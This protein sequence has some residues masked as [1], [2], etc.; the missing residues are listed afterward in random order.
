MDFSAALDL[1]KNISAAMLG[2][3][4]PKATQF[5]SFGTGTRAAA[6]SVA[7][8]MSSSVNGVGI[9][10]KN[11]DSFSIKVLTR[12]GLSVDHSYLSQYYG[13]PQ[14]DIL[15]ERVGRIE[16]KDLRSRQRPLFPG[17]SAG[18]YKI[19]AGTLGC[20]VEDE[21]KR[22][23]ILSNNHVLANTNKG[24]FND[25]IFQPGPLDGG[26]KTD[27]IARLEYL[28]N[29]ERSKPNAMDAALARVVAGI[30]LNYSVNNGTKRIS[31]IKDPALKL[32]VEK[33]GRT[34]GHTTGSITTR[35]LDL[36]VDYEGQLIDFEDQLEIKGDV[37]SGQRTLFC[38][39]GDSGSLITEKG[40]TN[41]VALL[42]AGAEDGTTFATPINEV[43]TEF[44]VK[45]L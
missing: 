41:A 26:K 19:T 5:I 38:A 12:D 39:G 2:K 36:Q 6:L 35:N 29:L 31:G 15:V 17:L 28:V 14:K 23:Y 37:K 11:D 3:K 1:K 21:K 8:D 45:I 25:P 44:S 34:T 40:T 32:K 13:V 9:T 22:I 16:F 18:H 43:L 4:G 33:Y 24:Y 27:E 20:F 42:F 7:R 10:K 30:N